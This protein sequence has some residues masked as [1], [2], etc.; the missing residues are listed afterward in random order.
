MSYTKELERLGI[1]HG[2]TVLLH[3][4]MIGL[5]WKESGGM[6]TLVEQ[7]Y[8]DLKEVIGSK[9][10]LVVPSFSFDFTNNSPN[11]YWSL[12]NSESDMGV[13]TE[14]IRKRTESERT[15]HPFYS[16]CIVGN[17]REDM[18]KSHSIDSFS[19]KYIFGRIHEENAKIIIL[20]TDYNNAMTFFHYIEQDNEVD[21][22][23]RYKKGF[24]GLIDIKG[25]EIE[26]EYYMMV[27]NLDMGVETNVNPMGSKLEDNGVIK[28]KKVCGGIARIG[29]AKEIYDETTRLMKKEKNLLYSL[30]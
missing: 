20:G 7:L 27:R 12:E 24:S 5:D 3:S 17:K 8:S 13:L 21:I 28:T 4:S 18:G 10:T 1:E 16:F 9:G 26:S 23:Y 11:G 19:R 22:E 14:Y 6:K 29:K 25:K 2:D 30:E 15:V